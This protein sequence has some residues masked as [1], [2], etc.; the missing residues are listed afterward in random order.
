VPGPT[1]LL[2]WIAGVLVACAALVYAGD[3]LWFEYRM[4]GAKSNDP[5]ETVNFYYATA[6]KNG[7]VEVFY[8]QPQ[9]ATCVHSIFAHGSYMPCRRFNRSGIQLIK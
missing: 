7:K 9:T 2:K 1:T 5:L 8:D 3:F 6:M 4:H